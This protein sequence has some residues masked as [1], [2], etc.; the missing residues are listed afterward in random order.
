METKCENW[1]CPYCEEWSWVGLK[2]RGAVARF[3]PRSAARAE[4]FALI[5][6]RASHERGPPVCRPTP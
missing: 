5:A 3:T 4:S 2:P 1:V 6:K